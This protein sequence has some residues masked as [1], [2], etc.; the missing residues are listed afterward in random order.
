[1]TITYPEP[2]ISSSPV[3][4]LIRQTVPVKFTYDVHFTTGL[5]RLNNLLL[6]QVIAAD[7]EQGPKRM[8]VVV[9]AG[10]A[11]CHGELLDQ[12][13]AYANH[14]ADVLTLSTAPI[15]VPGGEVVKNQPEL[16]EQIHQV[17]NNAGI[18][19][20]SYVVAIGGGAM[21]DMVGYAA[22]TAHRGVRLIRVPTTVLAQDDSAV[23]VKNSINA[24][25]KKNFLGTFAPPYAVLNDFSFLTTLDDRDWRSGMAEAVKVALI[26][27][28][29]FYQFIETHAVD[30]AQRDMQAMQQLIYRCAALHLDHIA[31]SGDPFELGT[32]RPLDFGHWAAH[33]LE[34]LTN[35][36][37]RHGEAVAIGI[38]LDS[39]YAYL[40][41][42][43]SQSEWQR[44]LNTLQTLGF[45][46]YIQELGEYVDQPHHPRSVFQGLTEF[47]E[48]LGGELTITLIRAIGHGLEVHHV[49]RSLY[50]QAIGMLQS[51]AA[52]P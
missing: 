36:R 3:P 42:L 27:D 41:D 34:H 45:T 39:T 12:I 37:L 15:V 21:L 32:A 35:Y 9:D 33:K 18:C 7:G 5:F 28:A 31:N 2:Q 1:M 20:H 24:F 26:K 48:H 22:A 38:A 19:R 11:R 6:A 4:P 8:V 43:L 40:S 23:G 13:V 17:I 47:Q 46:L 51:F 50:Q 25:G 44:I 16:V 49:D 52:E 10:V 30:L 29:A 14:H